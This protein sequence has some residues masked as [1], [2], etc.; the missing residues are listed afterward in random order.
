ME[1]RWPWRRLRAACWVADSRP[2]YLV[3][4]R[5]WS[6]P[7]RRP[8]KPI[9]CCRRGG[10]RRAGR[11]RLAPASH[12]WRLVEWRSRWR[13]RRGV[14]GWWRRCR[15]GRGRGFARSCG[16]P[17]Q[18]QTASV[19]EDGVGCGLQVFGVGE[20]VGVEVGEAACCGLVGELRGVYGGCL[21]P[22]GGLDEGEVGCEAV[23]GLGG[24]GR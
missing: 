10:R 12:D 13:L 23:G 22:G 4:A 6:L 24:G 2:A 8:R 5:C 14:G 17:D 20:V 15:R 1:R 9:S 7:R 16:R 19:R 3:A 11:G 21:V 18:V